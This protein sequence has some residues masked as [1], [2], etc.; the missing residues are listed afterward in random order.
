[1]IKY[2]SD[3]EVTDEETNRVDDITHDL[4]VRHRIDIAKMHFGK[5][6]G[7]SLRKFKRIFLREMEERPHLYFI[8][9]PGK[10]NKQDKSD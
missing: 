5:E 10:N 6:G 7:Y 8:D 9:R 2:M 4:Y 3:E 1:M